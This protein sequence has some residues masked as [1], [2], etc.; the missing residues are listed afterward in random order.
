MCVHWN[1]AE[2]F[3]ELNYRFFSNSKGRILDELRAFPLIK[4]KN[5]H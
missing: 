1:F 4:L 2:H 3:S 5:I